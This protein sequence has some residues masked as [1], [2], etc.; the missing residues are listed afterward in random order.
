MQYNKVSGG[1]GAFLDKKTL[2]NGQKAKIVSEC[3]PVERDYEGKP[4]TQH[5]AKVQ[6]Q[7]DAS[8]PKNVS[9][10]N[11][12]RNGL[13]DAYG[14][15]SKEWMGHTL[16]IYTEKSTI[17]G[18]RVIILYLLPEGY[19][20]SEDEG[21]YLVIQK[22]GKDVKKAAPEIVKEDPLEQEFINPEDIPFD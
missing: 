5:I 22:V 10:N 15:D 19:D 21:G 7:G 14:A 17:G 13:I 20:V 8:G 16:T 4:Q 9:L 12:T 2:V 3:M 18:K 6:V 11:A 1:Q